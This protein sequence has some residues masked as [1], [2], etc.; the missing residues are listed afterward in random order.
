M[1]DDLQHMSALNLLALHA[2]ISDELRA[3]GILRSSNSPTGDLA[4]NL[5]CKAFGWV[6]TGNSNAN[7][8]ATDAEGRRYQ[9]KARRLTAHNTSRQLSALRD[10]PA[11][12]FDFLAGLLFDSNYK[13]RRAAIIPRRLIE[14]SA[15]FV[16]RTNSHK[17]YLR[18]EV[19]H[20]PGVRDVTL[21]LQAVTL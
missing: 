4:E 16:V 12:H 18:D 5:F 11:G 6:Q 14:S 19:W 13:V 15:T 10:L 20:A 9:I 2:R 21:Q 8:D 7:Y 3:R 1:S 17:F